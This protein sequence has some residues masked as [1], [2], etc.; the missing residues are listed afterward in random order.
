MPWI[1]LRVVHD[2]RM[3]STVTWDDASASCTPDAV[4]RIYAALRTLARDLRTS[5]RAYTIVSDVLFGIRHSTS[6]I[7]RND[8]PAS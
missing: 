2:M 5:K 1:A 7:A 3:P 6:D 4:D 8:P